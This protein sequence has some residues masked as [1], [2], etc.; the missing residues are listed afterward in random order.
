MEEGNS[1]TF[2]NHVVQYSPEFS[3]CAGC[4]SCEV[5]CTLVH[6]GLV[7]PTH[8]RIFVDRDI[9]TMVHTILSCQQ[10]ADHPCYDKCPKQGSAMKIDE[11]NI[12]WIDEENC[13]GCGLCVKA[14]VFTPPRINLVKSTD[15][16]ERKA[17]KCDMCRTRPEGP[18]CI[19]WC[20]VRCIGES[21]SSVQV[22]TAREAK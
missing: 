20:P 7:S 17:K 16:S 2:G 13:I 19:E 10:C 3:F 9:R 12:V 15:K 22:T 11:N 4:S 5:V 1:R 14:C 8:N 6:D 21:A 18:A